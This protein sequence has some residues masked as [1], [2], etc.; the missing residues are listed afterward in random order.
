M[1]KFNLKYSSK[2]K[3]LFWVSERKKKKW[4]L[5]DPKKTYKKNQQKNETAELNQDDESQEFQDEIVCFK[6]P[7]LWEQK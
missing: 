3:R 2:H 6:V 1:T 5:Y 4:L 7:R